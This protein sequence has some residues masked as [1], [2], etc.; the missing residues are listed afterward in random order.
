[1]EALNLGPPEYNMSALNKPLGHIAFMADF[2]LNL[3]TKFT[4]VNDQQRIYCLYLF[5]ALPFSFIIFSLLLRARKLQKAR[6]VILVSST[7]QI[8]IFQHGGVLIERSEALRYS[9]GL[10]A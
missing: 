9:F 2:Y 5:P 10:L 4:K 7:P 6:G 8:R 1:M 3:A